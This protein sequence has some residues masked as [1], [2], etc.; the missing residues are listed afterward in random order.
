MPSGNLAQFC[1]VA[2][3]VACPS[4]LVPRI[5]PAWRRYPWLLALWKRFP[6]DDDVEDDG[7]AICGAALVSSGHAI[8]AAHCVVH[9]DSSL[10]FLRGRT[11]FAIRPASSFM[12]QFFLDIL[13]GT[14][15]NVVNSGVVISIRV[16]HVHE[17]FD[18]Q[19]FENDIAVLA[20]DNVVCITVTDVVCS[21]AF[22][23]RYTGYSS[24]ERAG[25]RAFLY[26]F[27]TYKVERKKR[28]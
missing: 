15:T 1:P 22:S 17:S 25:L 26:C 20:L 28:S 10:F 14:N 21:L 3:C 9:G 18:P 8:T 13:G 19:T 4:A 2:H 23:P 5:D 7:T 11:L 12:L 6:T 27:T 16:I 24:Q